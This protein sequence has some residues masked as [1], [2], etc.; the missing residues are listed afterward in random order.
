[1]QHFLR[2]RSGARQFRQQRAPGQRM[3]RSSPKATGNS[4]SAPSGRQVGSRNTP[5]V[6]GQPADGLGPLHGSART[7]MPLREAVILEALVNHPVAA[8]R[9][10][11]GIRPSLEFR[12]ADAEQLKGASST[13]SR[14]TAGGPMPTAI[15]AELAAAA[16]PRCMERIA[17]RHHHRRVWG[18]RPEAAPDDVL[19]TWQQLSPC[20]GTGIHYIRS[21]RTP[22]GAGP[23]IRPKRII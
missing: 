22:S 1:M 12:Y 19:V 11:R 21:S 6:A 3:A 8:A 23:P 14:M 2:R 4:A 9:P 5:Y 15:E 13:S 16:L 17:T 7:A 20:I 10:S 18:A